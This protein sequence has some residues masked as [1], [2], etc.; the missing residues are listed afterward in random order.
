MDSSPEF[1]PG[2]TCAANG[3]N[4]QTRPEAL[5]APGLFFCYNISMRDFVESNDNLAT[6]GGPDYPI[7]CLKDIDDKGDYKIYA[8][9]DEDCEVAKTKYTEIKDNKNTTV[10]EDSSNPELLYASVSIACIAV[11]L[12]IVGIIINILNNKKNKEEE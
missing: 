3:K 6:K 10:F 11:V 1:A 7:Y 4:T 2:S 9:T 8:K 12:I 5:F